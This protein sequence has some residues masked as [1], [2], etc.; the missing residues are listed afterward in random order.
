MKM[1]RR[2][3]VPITVPIASMGDIAFLLIIF[4]I[5]CSNF[6]KETGKTLQNPRALELQ[7]LASNSVV[8]I[9]DE[10]NRIWV[11]GAEVPDA[12]AVEWAVMAYLNDVEDAD[13][14]IVQF[15]CDARVPKNIFE[16]VIDSIAK[17]GA[18]LAAVADE[19]EPRIVER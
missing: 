12:E 6:V 15:R 18:S 1:A 17:A 4:F 11:N 3:R 13:K 19:G 9:V 14:R 2:K 7:V 10:E 5:L 16:P 8:V